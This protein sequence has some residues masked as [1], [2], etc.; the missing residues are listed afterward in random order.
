VDGIS[1]LPSNFRSRRKTWSRRR[2]TTGSGAG[3]PRDQT[4][5]ERREPVQESYDWDGVHETR[6]T[7]ESASV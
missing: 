5:N 1:P 3:E 4:R 2:I 6:Y 7:E